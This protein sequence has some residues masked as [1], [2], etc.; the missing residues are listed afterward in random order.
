MH[1]PKI[2]SVTVLAALTTAVALP[3]NSDV[4]AVEASKNHLERRNPQQVAQQIVRNA[5][6][7]AQM[8]AEQD[9]AADAVARPGNNLYAHL[10]L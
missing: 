10:I 7:A 1:F 3:F 4:H 6:T 5:V 2:I 8:Q 9:A